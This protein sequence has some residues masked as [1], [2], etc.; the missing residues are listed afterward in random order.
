MTDA[1]DVQPN[2][3]KNPEGCPTINSPGMAAQRPVHT[4][5]ATSC[6]P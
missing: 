3:K 1:G 2:P 5:K 4:Q 6:P